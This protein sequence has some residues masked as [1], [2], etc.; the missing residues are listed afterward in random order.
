MPK[1]TKES[2]PPLVKMLFLGLSGEGKSSSLVPLGIPGYLDNPGYELRILDFDGK[3]EEVV[4]STLAR[5][6]KEKTISQSQHDTAL[7]ENYDIMV[8]SE[9]VGV[10]SARE[11][12]RTIKKLGVDGTATAWNNAVRQLDKWSSSFGPNTI[13]V[14]DSFTHAVRA[15]TN[16]SQ[17]LNGKLNQALE[18]RD[19]QGP[20][21][22]AETLMYMAAD[23]P[24][25]AVVTAHQDP[26]EIVKPTTQLD[27][28]GNPVEEVVDVIMAPVSVGRAGRVKLPSKMN[29]LLVA[30][31]EGKGAAVRRYVYTTPRVGVTTK[32]PLYGLCEDRYS[33]DKAMVEYFKLAAQT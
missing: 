20:Q 14:V 32:T 1:L 26:L 9:T 6:L 25:H 21:H 16:F 28:K 27:E 30:S 8:C 22:L 24:T 17:E 12:K 11:G 5:M 19:Y 31:S 29:H 18:W 3:F 23:L 13:L 7:Y 2:K 33:L 10:V 4:R 15:I